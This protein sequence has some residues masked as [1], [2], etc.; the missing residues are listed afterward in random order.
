LAN[1]ALVVAQEASAR[2]DQAE[3]VRID[4]ELADRERLA[5][6]LRDKALEDAIAVSLRRDQAEQARVDAELADRE[7][8]ANEALAA[9]Q[10]AGA[11]RDQA[12]QA[13]V[14]VEL[15]DRERLANEALAAA[16]EAGARRDQAEQARVDAELAER[17]RLANEALAAAQEAGARRDQAEQA[18]V[19]VELAERERLANEALAA[20]QEASAKREEEELRRQALEEEQAAVKI[21][22][23]GRT[24]VEKRK[25]AKA[26]K[27]TVKIQSVARV[28]L[29]KGKLL[30]LRTAKEAAE[31]ARLRQERVEQEAATRIQ[32]FYRMFVEQRKFK[33]AGQIEAILENLQLVTNRA[34]L[35]EKL[36]YLQAVPINGFTTVAFNSHTSTK[37]SPGTASGSKKPKAISAVK[38]KSEIGFSKEWDEIQTALSS[39]QTEVGQLVNRNLVGGGMLMNEFNSLAA[40]ITKKVENISDIQRNLENN[41]NVAAN[42]EKSRQLVAKIYKKLEEMDFNIRGRVRPQGVDSVRRSLADDFNGAAADDDSM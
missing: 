38:Y 31:Q 7:R 12:E 22:S 9:A 26:K 39:A 32:S 8:L 5:D 41:I 6:E 11:R 15:A 14:D 23:V 17:E 40:N 21:Q 29:A 35:L 25:L 34:A 27:V 20:A 4:A 42:I 28:L 1:E 30:E 10:E 33:I 24:F 18:R 16:Q 37:K 13:R 36:E 2:R 19:D 3:R